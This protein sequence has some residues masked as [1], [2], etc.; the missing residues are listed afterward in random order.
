[1]LRPGERVKR[2]RRFNGPRCDDCDLVLRPAG[3]VS[4]CV[5]CGQFETTREQRMRILYDAF[6]RDD[7]AHSAEIWR[8]AQRV[9]AQKQL[10]MFDS[11]GGE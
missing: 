11:E 3:H 5:E 2:D 1:M 8:E 10:S 7:M 6:Y 4:V 9:K